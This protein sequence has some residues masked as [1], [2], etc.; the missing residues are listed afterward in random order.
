MQWREKYFCIGDIRGLGGMLGLELVKDKGTKEPAPDL[1]NALIA[2]CVRN[3]LMLESAGTY[4]N[5]IRFLA[6]LVITDEQL[7][8]GLRIM[9]QSLC[10]CLEEMKDEV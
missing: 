7:E 4:G 5:V 6:P 3:G 10:T 1:T 8:C 2:E 9:E